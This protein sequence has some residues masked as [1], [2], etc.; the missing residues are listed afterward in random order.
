MEK[1]NLNGAVEVLESPAKKFNVDFKKRTVNTYAVELSK[2]TFSENHEH[3]LE[4]E[5]EVLCFQ[6]E[7]EARVEFAK[8][9]L[10]EGI[11][12]DNFRN[13]D[14]SKD[15]I[16]F[17]TEIDEEDLLSCSSEILPENVEH[18][19]FGNPNSIR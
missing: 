4:S 1:E 18:N 7:A 3:L 12:V 14:E 6:T 15:L 5:T 8:H 9:D 10:Q 13:A 11:F 2:H 19:L 17:E 16:F